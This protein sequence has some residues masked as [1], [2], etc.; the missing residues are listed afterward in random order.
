[1]ASTLLDLVIMT[2]SS[3]FGTGS[4]IP[5]GSAATV[6]GVTYLSFAGAGAAGG[7]QVSYSILDTG[8]SE[9]G[10]ATYTSSNTTLTSRTP[11]KSTN[12]NA[13][14]TASSAALVLG[15]VRGE[16]LNAFIVAGQ[17]LATATNDNASAGNVGEIISATATSSNLTSGSPANVTSVT[18]TP[19]DWDVSAGF[20]FSGS[21]A[22]TSSDIWGAI[23]TSSNSVS[24]TAGQFYRFR[25]AT[26]SDPVI[27]G[28]AGPLRVSSSI[29][30]TYFANTQ[31]IF[32]GGT[33]FNVVATMRARRPR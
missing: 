9:I 3:A 8:N 11:T 12:G 10:T 21:G 25:G 2:P 29:S 28:E 33:A 16:D 14:I 6:S 22:P 27:G 19:G 30:V 5:L 26:L 17:L 23:S 13:A 20:F 31:V 32:S 15:A 1:V 7:S 24:N 4:T 18:L